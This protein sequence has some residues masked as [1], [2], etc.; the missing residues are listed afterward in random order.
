[1]FKSILSLFKTKPQPQQVK[2]PIEDIYKGQIRLNLNKEKTWVWNNFQHLPNQNFIVLGQQGAGKTQNILS[3]SIQW[4]KHVPK[5]V[6]IDYKE[7]YTDSKYLSLMDGKAYF[8]KREPLPFNPMLSN[9]F[10]EIPV[11]DIK[12]R[13]QS[14][15]SNYSGTVGGNQ[16]EEIRD[17]ISTYLTVKKLKEPLSIYNT[18]NELLNNASKDSKNSIKNALVTFASIC[19]IETLELDNSKH[20][21]IMYDYHVD[22]I[23]EVENFSNFVEFSVDSKKLSGAFVGKVLKPLAEFNI[24]PSNN[25]SFDDFMDA[26]KTSVLVVKGMYSEDMQNLI[27][28][29]IIEHLE[30]FRGACKKSGITNGKYRDIEVVL[31]LDEARTLMRDKVDSL[32]K[33]L[34]EGR[35]FGFVCVFGSQF[36]EDFRQISKVNYDNYFPTVIQGK[37]K[38][39]PLEFCHFICDGEEIYITPYF[40]RVQ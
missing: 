12:Y 10:D 16:E 28:L 19:G 4:A 32:L 11:R 20:M 18:A 2:Q 21:E 5:T 33:L 7:D 39:F 29:V 17:A 22:N 3:M 40:K 30:A 24:F 14:I 1:M 8:L 9:K 15:I 6:I 13:L 23:D 38:D 37:N 27:S 25:V 35:E 36:I 26:E 34:K 31:V